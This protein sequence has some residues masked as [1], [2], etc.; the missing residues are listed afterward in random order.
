MKIFWHGLLGILS[1]FYLKGCVMRATAKVKKLK[2]LMKGAKQSGLTFSEAMEKTGC[3]CST[4]YRKEEEMGIKLLREPRKRGKQLDSH[5]AKS[6]METIPLQF[7][8]QEFNPNLVG[9]NVSNSKR[10]EELE[11]LALR[12][13]LTVADLVLKNEAL[14]EASREK[15]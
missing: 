4:V 7:E 10:I 13:K 5:V 14:E 12:L 2:E 3:S 1:D 8:Q 11:L 9:I 15:R 6:A